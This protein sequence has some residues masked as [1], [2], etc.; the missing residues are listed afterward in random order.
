MSEEGES[1]ETTVNS[2]TL[3]EEE[4]KNSLLEFKLSLINEVQ[5]MRGPRTA[6]Y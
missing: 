6:C 1:I 5:T 3:E 4:K 2:K